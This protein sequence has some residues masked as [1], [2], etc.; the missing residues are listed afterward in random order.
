[1]LYVHQP[2]ILSDDL[3]DCYPG[4]PLRT[5]SDCGTETVVASSIQAGLRSLN[6]PNE[7]VKNFHRY[8]PSYLNQR[9]ECHWSQYLTRKG[10]AI[11]DDLEMEV[12]R[13]TYNP[14]DPLE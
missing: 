2:F 9:I 11:M 6:E 3:S 5:T 1:M 4:I 10:R 8:V 14:A 12:A 7:N 13:G